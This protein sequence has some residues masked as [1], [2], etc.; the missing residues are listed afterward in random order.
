MNDMITTQWDNNSRPSP[1]LNRASALFDAFGRLRVSDVPPL[2]DSKLS[3]GK[4][5]LYWDEAVSANAS[6]LHVE[7]DSCVNLTVTA[8]GAYA[9]R[10][11]RQ[12]WNY[13]P[14]RSQNILATFKASTA[15]G[16]TCRVGPFHGNFTAP[17]TPHDGIYFKVS[18]GI[19]SCNIVKGTETGGVVSSQKALQSEWNI[20]RLDGTGPSGHV[21]DWSKAQILAIDFQWLGIGGVRFGIEVYSVTHYV[22]EFKHAGI[23]ESVYMH[24]GT[25]PIRYEI[26]STGGTG[27]L[28]QICTSVSSEGGASKTGITTAVYTDG[29]LVSCPA[30]VIEML[31]AIRID[32]GNPDCQLLVEKAYS[33]NT[34]ANTS[35]RWVILFNPVISGT[36][37]WVALPGG[38]PIQVWQNTG[39]AITMTGGLPLDSGYASRDNRQSSDTTDPSVNPGISINGTPDIIALGI[40]SIGGAST[41]AGGLGI[42]HLV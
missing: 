2:F 20:D 19:A 33:L 5:P 8:N 36:P 9:V 13:Q 29:V 42:R 26:R 11:T 22:H 14:G 24:N 31:L 15:Q 30:G 18:N 10:Q 23:V 17:Y 37:S 3:L 21:A 7:V 28:M 27:T 6:S 39:T 32:P 1:K 4:L 41:C 16:V 12:R 35:Y 34:A 38:V 40:E 25:Q